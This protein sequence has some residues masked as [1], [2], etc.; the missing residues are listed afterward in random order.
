MILYMYLIEILALYACFLLV[1][2]TV[3]GVCFLINL[4]KGGK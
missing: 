4:F 3:F 1:S 2:Y